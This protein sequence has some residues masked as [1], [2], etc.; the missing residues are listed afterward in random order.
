MEKIWHHTFFGELRVDPAEH[1][2][3]L[4]EAAMNPRAGRSVRWNPRA[5]PTPTAQVGQ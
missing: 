2:V 5:G 4:T 1:K 3:M